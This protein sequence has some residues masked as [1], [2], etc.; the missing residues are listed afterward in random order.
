MRLALILNQGRFPP[1]ALPGFIGTTSPSVTPSRPACPSRASGWASRS[2]TPW[3]FPCCAVFLFHACHRHYPGGTPG[4]SL[5][6]L[7]QRWQPSPCVSRVGFRVNLFEA[8]SAFTH[9]TACMFAKSLSG[10]STPKASAVSLPPRLLRLLPAGATITGRASHPLKDR[11]FARRTNPLISY[12]ASDRRIAVGGG[13]I[14]APLPIW[15]LPAPTP[16]CPPGGPRW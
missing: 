13:E 10:P 15:N 16:S 3:A 12:D 8:C 4:G 11:A 5:R 7:P 1:P 14:T 9:V 6:S 2:P